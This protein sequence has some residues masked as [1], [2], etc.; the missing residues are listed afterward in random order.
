MRHGMTLVMALVLGGCV[1]VV[2]PIE[3]P[4]GSD[5]ALIYEG[6]PE[7]G[8]ELFR[9]ALDG[10]TPARLFP[11]GTIRRSP[12]V[13]PDGEWIAFVVW[14]SEGVSEIHRV[15][16]NGTGLQRL[17]SS[18]E[19]DDQ[20]VWSPDGTKILFRSWRRQRAG[21]IWVM[22]ADGSQQRNLTPDVGQAIIEYAYPTWSPDGQRIAYHSNAG[23]DAGIWTMR[24]D[25]TDRR[26]LTN[27][28]D[29]DT[30]PNW[31]P[32]GQWIYFRRSSDLTGSEIAR[33]PAS[34]GVVGRYVL[35]G[36]QRMPR[37]SPDGSR[38]A[39][40]TYDEPFSTGRIATMRPDGS[41]I[42]LHTP[43]GTTG[44]I[45]PVWERRP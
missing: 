31:S 27:T 30:E 25:G 1:E 8:P 17:T 6:R 36:E 45:A 15:R 4:P 21:E 38:I 42:I 29:F 32:D 37:W 20:P 34:G 12:T 10:S 23:G 14:N 11:A 24:A 3:P 5:Y 39:F 2:G 26:Q 7:G 43:L 33:I 18:G 13:S 28:M 40:V 9:V 35:P 22:N 44:G 19:D 41:D 16:R